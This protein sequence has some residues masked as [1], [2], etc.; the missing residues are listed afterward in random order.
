MPQFPVTFVA[1]LF[2]RLKEEKPEFFAKVKNFLAFMASLVGSAAAYEVYLNVNKLPVPEWLHWFVYIWGGLTIAIGVHVPDLTIKGA[3]P[4]LLNGTDA[5]AMSNEQLYAFIEAQH[6]LI[7]R[8]QA[9]VS[10]EE[11]KQPIDTL[12]T[13]PQSL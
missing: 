9:Q 12:P 6:Q 3:A 2:A 7:T 13:K 4:P 11:V 1:Q 10:Q 8:L 5:K